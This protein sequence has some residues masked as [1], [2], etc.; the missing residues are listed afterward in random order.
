MERF[1][2]EIGRCTWW[3]MDFSVPFF[4]GDPEDLYYNNGFSR[5][6]NY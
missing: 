6:K 5:R 4:G 1:R 2:N 3:S